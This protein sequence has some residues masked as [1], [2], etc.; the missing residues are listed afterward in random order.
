LGDQAVNAVQGGADVSS[1]AGAG[2]GTGDIISGLDASTLAG[3][4]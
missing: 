3:V 2:A 1:L 4:F